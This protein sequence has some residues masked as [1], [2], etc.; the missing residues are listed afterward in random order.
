MIQDNPDTA[1]VVIVH[2][3][4]SYFQS[5]LTEKV[6]VAFG[7]SRKISII[8]KR[9]VHGVYAHINTTVIRA[10]RA[11][12]SEPDCF[13]PF[14]IKAVAGAGRRGCGFAG[15]KVPEIRRN[16]TGGTVDERNE[17]LISNDV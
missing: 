9:R 15:A 5:V 2:F 16:C 11:T 13:K 12:D 10:C 4:P 6:D 14:P 17:G 7:L 8:V 3:N 1:I